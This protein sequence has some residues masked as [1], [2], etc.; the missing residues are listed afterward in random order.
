MQTNNELA[1]RR[2]DKRF[3]VMDGGVALVTPPGPHST[4]VGD[5]IDISM[6]G[7]SFR[8]LADKAL[9]AEAKELTIASARDKFYL[10]GLPIRAVSDFEIAKIPFG[11]LSPR[12]YGLEFGDLTE[13][14]AARL[15]SFI[16]SHATAEA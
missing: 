4:V 1:E 11:S 2:R 15:E 14:Q 16:A 9:P 5:I 12:R 6:N 10:R 13:E 8:Y 7:L 3:K